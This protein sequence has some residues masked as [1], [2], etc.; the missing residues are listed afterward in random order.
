MGM[1]V[2]REFS[3]L[4]KDA[5]ILGPTAITA[6]TVCGAHLKPQHGSPGHVVLEWTGVGDIQGVFTFEAGKGN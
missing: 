2:G 1:K 4:A 5:G 6:C 3:Q